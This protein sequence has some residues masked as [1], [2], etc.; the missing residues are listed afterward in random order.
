ME[1]EKPRRGRP[2]KLVKQINPVRQVGRWDDASWQKVRDAAAKRGLSVAA[3]ARQLL[4]RA[5][6]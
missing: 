5:A 4:L 3:W 1:T 2:P 6:K